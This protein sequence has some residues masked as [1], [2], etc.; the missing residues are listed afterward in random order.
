LFGVMTGREREVVRHLSEEDLDRLLTETDDVKVHERLVFIKRL[1][2][3]AT[4]AEAA[5]DVGRSEGKA[6]N[7]VER[8][9]EGGLGKLT[10]NFG[11]GRGIR[12]VAPKPRLL[13][14][15]DQSVKRARWHETRL[16]LLR[17]ISC[18]TLSWDSRIS[19]ESDKTHNP[20]AWR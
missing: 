17:P 8:W 15:L 1:Y 20:I 7:W 9:N 5:D 4:L 18:S 10:P 13:T 3:G 12:A 2:K 11:G 19:I 16:G 14:H 6:G